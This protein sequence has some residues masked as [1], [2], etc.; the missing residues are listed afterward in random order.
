MEVGFIERCN[1]VL[2]VS[3]RTGKGHRHPGPHHDSGDEPI[4]T[5]AMVSLQD[6]D[7]G[8]RV[9]DNIGESPGSDGAN[10]NFV[11]FTSLTS[12]LH[13]ARM[14]RNVY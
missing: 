6:L 12:I 8:V 2:L 14:F 1:P 13:T 7:D 5:N 4:E 11:P 10:S 3:C 9:L